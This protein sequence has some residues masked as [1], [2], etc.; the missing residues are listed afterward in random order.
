MTV[1]GTVAGV[2]FLVANVGTILSAKLVK[3]HPAVLLALSSRNRHLLLTKGAGIG[4]VAFAL[5]PLVRTVPVALSY[6]LMAHGYGEQGRAWMER[7]AGGVPGTVG[8][9]ERVFDR[10]GPA[11]LLLFA[12][13]QLAWLIAG[14]RKIPTRTFLAFEV[15][16]IAARVA[17]FWILGERFKKQIT[18]LLGVIGRKQRANCP[19]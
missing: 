12:G 2:S 5:I 7:E 13:S 17:F 3:S 4:F 1:L 15:A 11:T 8:W 19:R 6:F 14:L 9:A 16:G 10:L 18:S